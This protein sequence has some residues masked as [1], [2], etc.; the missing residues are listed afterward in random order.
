MSSGYAAQGVIPFELFDQQLDTGTVVVK[1]PEVERLQRQIG[2]Q[3]VVVV[4]AELEERQLVAGLVGLRASYDDEAIRMW[5]AGRLVAKLGDLDPAT[6]AGLP[7]GRQL[8]FDRGCQASDA[9]EAGSLLF[10]PLDQRMVVNPFVHADDHQP[11]PGRNLCETG[12]QEV[13]RPAGGMGIAGPQFAMPEVL[14]LALET[15]Q[16]MIGGAAALDRVVAD[17]CLFLFARDSKKR[18]SV[19]ASG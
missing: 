2:D 5:P 1:A 7:Q 13:E 12:L 8:A 3:D 18:R 14:A 15:E 10:E 6:R 9:H 19:V 4:L 17:P 11:D 16:G